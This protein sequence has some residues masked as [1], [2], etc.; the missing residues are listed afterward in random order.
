MFYITRN[1]RFGVSLFFGALLGALFMMSADD[2]LR[3]LITALFVMYLFEAFFGLNDELCDSSNSHHGVL[4]DPFLILNIFILF[5][6]LVF[7]IICTVV[8][9]L[10]GHPYNQHALMVGMA[11]TVGSYTLFRLLLWLANHIPAKH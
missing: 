2:I 5:I 1:S 10:A 8:L 4:N 7:G 11:C 9:V 6:P 3:G